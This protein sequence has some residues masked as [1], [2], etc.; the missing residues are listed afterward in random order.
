MAQQACHLARTARVMPAV[1]TSVLQVA[2]RVGLPLSVHGPGTALQI[3]FGRL[4][5]VINSN[6]Q[7]K[8]PGH[9]NFNVFKSSARTIKTAIQDAW[10]VEVQTSVL[11]RNGLDQFPLP[12]R[13]IT[14]K[15]FKQ[16]DTWE[17]VIL[18]RHVRGAFLS[19][20]EKSTWSRI[21]TAECELCGQMDTKHH[22]LYTCPALADVRAEHQEILE[23]VSNL[24]P[25]WTHMLAAQEPEDLPFLCLV[26]QTR[27]L[28]PFVACPHR[29]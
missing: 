7:F 21:I 9:V 14:Q 22:R 6:G 3:M 15:L 26:Q 4:G 27:K 1:A 12:S 11:D 2:S 13:T 28:P 16:F 8:G 10:A 24:Y 5:W 23:E 18:S 29:A 19:N 25:W 17:Q 20:A